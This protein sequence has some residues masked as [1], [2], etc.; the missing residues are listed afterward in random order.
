MKVAITGIGGQLG[1][2]ILALEKSFPDLELFSYTRTAWDISDV[3]RTNAIFKTQQFDVL[4][5]AA[6]Y[7]AVDQAE[8][9]LEKAMQINGEAVGNLAEICRLNKC[10]LIHISTDYVFDGMHEEPISESMMTAPIN[11]YGH[12]KLFGEK[13]AFEANPETIVIRTSWLYSTYGKN[14]FKTINSLSET[15][16]T[17]SVVDDQ[18]GT[19]TYAADLAKF[20]LTI[21]SKSDGIQGIFHFSNKGEATWYDFAQEIIALNGSECTLNRVDSDFF[22]QKAERPK[23]SI[24][25]KS[26]TEETFSYN[27]PDWR[28]AL[29]RC[30]SAFQTHTKE[31]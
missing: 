8:D 11:N 28:E 26:K 25:D 24:L 13:A 12:T 21:C 10:K 20:L 30:W 18:H 1:Q 4:I 19:P 7:T 14:F 15:K 16:K 6:A 31:Q 27:I 22:E 3:L 5:N 23:Y 29:E 2:E 17:L 9:E